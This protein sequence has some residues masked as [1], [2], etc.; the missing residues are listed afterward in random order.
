MPLD[1]LLCVIRG[2][3]DKRTYPGNLTLTSW[4]DPKFLTLVAEFVCRQLVKNMV[5][6]WQA[7]GDAP[8]KPAETPDASAAVPPG[9]SRG[10]TAPRDFSAHFAPIPAGDAALHGVDE[11]ARNAILTHFSRSKAAAAAECGSF[12]AAP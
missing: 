4:R 5:A 3:V 11:N 6:T 10:R 1:G 12:T 2:R 9:A 7:T 8:E